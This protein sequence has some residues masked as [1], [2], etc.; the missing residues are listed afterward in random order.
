MIIVSTE[1]NVHRVIEVQSWFMSTCD[2]E[3]L[4]DDVCDFVLLEEIGQLS[5]Y[6]VPP[7][8]HS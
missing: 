3:K 2:T 6:V 4:V 5:G 8:G 1:S 7:R